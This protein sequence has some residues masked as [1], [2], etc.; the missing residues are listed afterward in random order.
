MKLLI[1]ILLFLQLLIF[2]FDFSLFGHHGA[3]WQLKISSDTLYSSAS[4]G[5]INIWNSNTG[6][7][8]SSI[9]SH[10][11]WTRSLFVEEKYIIAGGYKPD[12]TLK[13]YDKNTGKL[14]KI[15][16]SE[17]SIFAIF[18]NEKYIV[19]GGSD[20]KVHIIDKTSLNY[21]ARH[22]FHERWVR[23]LVINGNTLISCGDDG[24]IIFFDLQK[25]NLI[26]E[27]KYEERIIKII[28]VNG[29]IYGVSSQ[30][31][32]FDSSTDKVVFQIDS[33]INSSYADKDYIY[34]GNNNGT[35]YILD[36]N[37]HLI[38]YIKLTIDPIISICSNNQLIFVGTSG[39]KILRYSI[40][41]NSIY[42]FLNNFSII[43]KSILFDKK[44][45]ILKTNGSL[46]SYNTE[47]GEVF[48]ENLNDSITNFFVDNRGEIYYSN[49]KNEIINP[50]KQVVFNSDNGVSLLFKF[51]EYLFIGTYGFIYILEDNILEN[52]IQLENEW[53]ISYYFDDNV[54]KIG[55]SSGKIYLY[56]SI[57]G[58]YEFFKISNNPIIKIIGNYYITFKGE[59]FH[60]KNLIYDL[61]TNVFDSLLTNNIFLLTSTDGIFLFNL[62]SYN[63][64]KINTEYP[65]ISVQK[66]QYIF[67]SMS[68][69]DVSIFDENLKEVRKLSE[70]EAKIITVD[71]SENGKYVATGGADKKI[72]LWKIENG[73]LILLKTFVGHNDWI[74][75][76]KFID[77]KFLISGSSDN[78]IK[79][80]NFNGQL[81]K[82]LSYHSGYV[83]SL[84]YKNGLLFSGGWDNKLIIFDLNSEKIIYQSNF[85]HSITHLEVYNNYLFISL[86][87]GEIK[88]LNLNTFTIEE[89]F[90]IDDTI[91][92]FDIFDGYLSFGD[93]QGFCYLIDI[94]EKR[95]IN[96]FQA[97]RTTI[98]N[99]KLSKNKI[100]TASNDNTI[101][102][103]DFNGKLIGQIKD[104]T[105][106][107]LAI[108]IDPIRNMII[109]SSGK[110]PIILQIP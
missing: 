27:K 77:S 110:N 54:I 106:S 108:A 75:T 2:S 107:V 52:Y 97:H 85:K 64:Q 16:Q 89:V 109:S 32:I 5:V 33:T 91:W 67:A 15:F 34:L 65:V 21:L 94:N 28:L 12:S 47:T 57:S 30:G 104:F 56:D 70:N 24:K 76:I 90:S 79:I 72:K 103:F 99:V 50:Q 102:I 18:S 73:N 66:N 31:K 49:S 42:S 98:F 20:N 45:F 51:G 60:N 81:I 46:I 19:Y 86:I 62:T 61:K 88:R 8:I 4:D 95:L 13:I 6:N 59:I 84:E 100:I 41:D 87:N 40:K 69:G 55:T 39:G 82:T 17:S 9:Y 105:L 38:N 1:I 63:T 96:K 11:S 44:L 22:T 83:W 26:A 23:D 58:N 101:K 78:T 36:H 3:I 43:K 68:N 93:E 14:V 92:N 35:L 37:F 74:R 80:W 48:S 10:N 71:L 25:F 53:P 7:L 29:K